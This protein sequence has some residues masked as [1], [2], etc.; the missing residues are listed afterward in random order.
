MHP[1]IQAS[2]MTQTNQLEQSVIENLDSAESEIETSSVYF[3]PKP[4]K[5]YMI[6]IDPHDKIVPRENDRFKD[7]N[8][9]PIKRYEFK[10]AHVDND[11]EQLWDT[12]KTVCLQIRANLKSTHD[13]IVQ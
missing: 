1:I 8:G 9:K 4:D 6:K 2:N 13:S 12:S 10:I 5:V 7:S 3:K 11:K